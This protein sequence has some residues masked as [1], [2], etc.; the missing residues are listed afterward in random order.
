MNRT[1]PDCGSVN[2]L[3]A[4]TCGCGRQLQKSAAAQTRFPLYLAALPLILPAFFIGNAITRSIR[5]A[6]VPEVSQKQ[7]PEKQKRPSCV[8][9][10][11]VTLGNNSD[12]KRRYATILH[13]TVHNTC[14]QTLTNV[15]LHFV[16][17]D[18]RGTPEA[19]DYDINE[20]RPSTTQTF[21]FKRAGLSKVT[22]WEITANK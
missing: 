8:E 19:G 9:T 17:R 13:G 12:I 14:S 6:A 1:C 21:D 5:A 15:V 20:L 11:G 22:T 2:P 10:Y 4:L 3:A 18:D 16:L 7:Q